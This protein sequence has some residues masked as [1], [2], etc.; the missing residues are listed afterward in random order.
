VAVSAH[1]LG[2]DRPA[3][4]NF[5]GLDW[6]ILLSTL[7]LAAIGAATV[8]SASAEMPVDYLPRQLLWIGIGV[9]CMLLVAA[10]NYRTLIDLALVFYALGLGLLVAVLF[11]GKVAGG[12]RGW[13]AF[14]GFA[15]QPAEIAKLTTALFLARYLAGINKRHLDLKQIGVSMLI[16]ASPMVLLALQPDLGSAVMYLPM[17]AGMLLVAGVRWQVLAA[18]ALVLVLSGA[19]LWTF[20]LHDYQRERVYTFVNPQADPLGAGYQVQQSK[21]AVGSGQ[22]VGK[23]YLEGTQSKLR[24][25]PAGH[26]DFIFAVLA[27]EWGFVGTVVVLALYAVFILNGLRVALRARERAAVIL[28]VGLLSLFAFHVVY[29]TAMVV[30]FVPITG[31]PLP[32]LSYGGSFTTLNFAIAGL[33]LGI[34]VRRYANA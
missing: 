22:L 13:F 34:D 2:E 5:S 25:L 31:I 26:T 7:L 18:A 11:Y 12:A 23:G 21:I 27:E 8:H 33:L 29:N 19:G 28:V 10:F 1:S 24:F 16:V 20:G 4:R 9:V 14:G 3:L 32:F 6:A 17:L 30:G 15:V